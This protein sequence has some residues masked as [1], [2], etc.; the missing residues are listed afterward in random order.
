MFSAIAVKL[1]AKVARK[2]R[3]STRA[4]AE[5]STANDDLDPYPDHR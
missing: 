2:Q 1:T 4:L 3:R 5:E